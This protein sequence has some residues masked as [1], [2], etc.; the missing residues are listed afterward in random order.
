MVLSLLVVAAFQWP[1]VPVDSCPPASATPNAPAWFDFQV[2]RPA[3]FA[4]TAATLPRPD[5]SL[6]ERPPYSADFAL[7][8]FVVDTTGVPAE[9]TLKILMRPSGLSVDA[10]KAALPRWRYT[11]AVARGC[12]VSQLVQT[13]L[14]WK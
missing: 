13:P 4:K 6:A 10:I 1:A 2:D 5:A 3:R 7:V 14:K 9:R 11:P 12:K 8:Q